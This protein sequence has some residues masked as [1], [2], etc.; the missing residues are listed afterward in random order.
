MSANLRRIIT[1]ILGI[2]VGVALYVVPD[3]IAN[4]GETL[5]A[6]LKAIWAAAFLFIGF[7]AW[8]T[9]DTVGACFTLGAGIALA[10]LLAAGGVIR[11]QELGDGT[12]D[13]ASSSSSMRVASSSV[14]SDEEEIAAVP[15]T[16]VK[17]ICNADVPSTWHVRSAAE[18]AIWNT[19]GFF[20]P[21]G[22]LTA[23]FV[24]GQ[25]RGGLSTKF[26]PAVFSMAESGTLLPGHSDDPGA[27]DSNRLEIDVLRLT[28]AEYQKL[29]GLLGDTPP[30][31]Y[32]WSESLP[33]RDFQVPTL[34]DN[35]VGGKYSG[36]ELVF[37]SIDAT[38]GDAA[39]VIVNRSTDYP[40]AT[41]FRE[42]FHR[43]IK[44]IDFSK[45]PAEWRGKT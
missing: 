15:V 36:Q 38:H 40:I 10:A 20:A 27:E 37:F 43:F 41:S 14:S 30:E 1:I 8:K 6:G 11:S 33:S 4:P 17:G 9:N 45:C 24:F 18:Q 22:V 25:L 21:G 39:Y 31:P 34:F 2:A 5:S 44:T 29:L 7:V 19:E 42:G 13:Q 16:Y 3:M 23:D 28:D 32:V 26:K 35:S 12:V